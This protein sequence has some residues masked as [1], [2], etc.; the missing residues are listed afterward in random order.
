MIGKVA[1][2]PLVLVSDSATGGRV[3]FSA[4]IPYLPAA[5][6]G[7]AHELRMVWSVQVLT[8]IPCDPTDPEAKAAGCVAASRG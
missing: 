8:D 7:S 5:N 6:W 4:R 1:Y 3:A 2:V